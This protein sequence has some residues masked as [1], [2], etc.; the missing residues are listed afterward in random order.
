MSR[1]RDR[2][3]QKKKTKKFRKCDK[4]SKK[5]KERSQQI[6]FIRASNSN[7]DRKIAQIMKNTKTTRQH[8]TILKRR[9]RERIDRKTRHARQCAR[10]IRRNDT[11]FNTIT[12]TSQSLRDIVSL[13]SRQ[14]NFFFSH[15]S[16][17]FVVFVQNSVDYRTCVRC[18][19]LRSTSRFLAFFDVEYRDWCMFCLFEIDVECSNMRWCFLEMHEAFFVEFRINHKRF[20]SCARCLARKSF[21]IN[22]ILDSFQTFVISVFESSSLSL[23]AFAVSSLDWEFIA[24]FYFSLADMRR[25]TCDVCNETNFNMKIR[26][27][28][29][30]FE[31]AKCRFDRVRNEKNDDFVSLWRAFNDLNSQC[32]SFHLSH[33]FIVEKL[34]IARAHVLMNYRRMK[35]CQYKYFE[36]VV[37][38]MQNTIKI[39]HRLLSLS[40]ELQVLILKLASRSTK[41][42]DAQRV[43][44]RI[45]RV[46][47]KHVEIWLK[48]L[49]KHHSDYKTI[50]F[51][52]N[53]LIQMSK[54]ESIWNKLFCIDDSISK[55]DRVVLNNDMHKRV[56]FF[57]LCVNA[58]QNKWYR[59]WSFNH[60]NSL[61]FEHNQWI[62]WIKS[63]AESFSRVKNEWRRRKRFSFC[64]F[65]DVRRVCF[66]EWAQ[67]S[68][69]HRSNDI[70]DAFFSRRNL[71]Q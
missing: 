17:S 32:L 50:E 42:S 64:L 9:L 66:I 51:D 61:C 18:D 62:Y 65:N 43:F 47:R 5:K 41:K 39:I 12:Q 40:F 53:R 29:K 20:R 11:S 54:D 7:L 52:S 33:F 44:E 24:N 38:F 28:E 1:K 31:C 3:T 55:K 21:K 35:D 10:V 58:N 30:M 2:T 69:S 59:R 26:V 71:I 68:S 25:E 13:S 14:D 23:Q 8:E 49:I 70:L 27:H 67:H 16:R 15:H 19:L 63:F 48:F 56:T 22:D 36:H 37:N 4:S 6:D 45:F 46:R 34:L 60:R 57:S